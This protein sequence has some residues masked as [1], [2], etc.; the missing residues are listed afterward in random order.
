VNGRAIRAFRLGDPHAKR[1]VVLVGVMHGS[2]RAPARTLRALRDGRRSVA[3]VNL[4]VIPVLNL[5]GAAAGRRTNAHGVDLNRNFPGNWSRSV[6]GAGP[7]AASEPETRALV[8]FLDRI[9]PDVVVSLHQP[10]AVVDTSVS[11]GPALARA[12][13]RELGLPRRDVGC[14][15]PCHGTLTRWFNRTHDGE[16]ITVEFGAHPTRTYLLR[17]AKLG[18]LAAVGGRLT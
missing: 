17:T 14:G 2:E 7:K 1:T 11:K 12:L 13:G 18:L 10:F 16:A 5:D 9:D 8:R 15:G 3:G 6:T 4:W